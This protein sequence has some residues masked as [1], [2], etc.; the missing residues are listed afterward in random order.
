MCD[1]YDKI[2]CL[3]MLYL[4]KVKNNLDYILK[5]DRLRL[6]FNHKREFYQ[7]EKIDVGSLKDFYIS[8]WLPTGEKNKSMR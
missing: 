7:Q 3:S 4:L 2:I 8:R 6:I 5:K 1:I